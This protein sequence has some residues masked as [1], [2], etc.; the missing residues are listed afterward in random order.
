MQETKQQK[1]ERLEREIPAKLATRTT[2]S[3]VQMYEIINLKLDVIKDGT[4]RAIHLYVLRFLNDELESR[5]AEAFDAFLDSNEKSPRKFF[6][7]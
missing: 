3:I 4:E 2:L 7:A 1:I 5:N 6:L